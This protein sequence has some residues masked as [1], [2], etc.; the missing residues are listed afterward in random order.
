M[1]FFEETM[2]SCNTKRQHTQ[3]IIQWLSYTPYQTVDELIEHAEEAIHLLY[4]N[5]SIAQTPTNRHVYLSAIMAYL[6]HVRKDPQLIEQ[7]KEYQRKN[8]EPI[9]DHYLSNEPTERQKDKKMDVKRIEEIRVS[10]KDGSLERLLLTFYT[11]MEPV[12]ADHYATELIMEGEEAK[13]E[14]YI[15][16]P[17]G[18]LVIRDFKMKNKH[19][20]I[21]NQLSLEVQEELE[22]SLK[23]YPRSHLFVMEDKKTPFT[24]KLFSNWACRTLTRIIGQPMTLTVLRHLYITENIKDHTLQERKDMAKKMGHS[25]GMQR[26]YDWS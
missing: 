25:M 14:N 12:R 16:M 6:T 7:W 26:V 5:A 22:T 20:V 21:E 17:L 1:D 19:N 15:I 9:A 2:L 11:R 18:R 4:T 8:W 13:E 23:L 3:K 24:R 10:L